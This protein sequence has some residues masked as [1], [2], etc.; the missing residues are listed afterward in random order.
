MH[1]PRYD[2]W[3]LPKGKLNPG[4]GHLA[5]ARRE[6]LEETGAKT[7]V[8]RRLGSSRYA[9]LT[10][11]GVVPK[12]VRWWALEEVGGTFVP[13]HEVDEL[14]WL[15]PDAALLQLGAGHDEKPLRRFADG[16]AQSRLVL[17]VRH[18]SA[19]D[20]R[21]WDGDDD[22][23]PLDAKGMRQSAALADVL[24][25]YGPVRILAAPPRRCTETV[26]PLA[27]RLGLPVEPDPLLADAAYVCDPGDVERHVRLLGR[28]DGA[29][30]ACGQGGAVPDVISRL[31]AGSGRRVKDVRTRKAATWALSLH[32][33]LLI[34]ADLLPPPR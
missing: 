26:R 5:A 30:V 24:A 27:E 11:E 7:R 15:S 25:A 12:V 34:D 23:R 6:V 10:P 14:R 17:L 2:D 19:G 18:A 20:R 22:A 4:E 9:V 8:G 28:P 32:D 3:S 21:A 29:V 1:R 16:P 13:G 31:A 33:G